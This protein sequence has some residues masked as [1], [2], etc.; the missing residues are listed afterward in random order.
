MAGRSC[1][2]FLLDNFF[3][4]GQR[5]LV[6]GNGRLL[7]CKRTW[8]QRGV[9]AADGF[10]EDPLLLTVL[11][12][13]DG[14]RRSSIMRYV[15]ADPLSRRALRLRQDVSNREQVKIA[16]DQSIKSEACRDAARY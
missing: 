7:S 16:A 2:V 1:R 13:E 5:V 3:D 12:R 11:R 4:Y 10:C 14:L 8:R 6:I 15:A 9:H